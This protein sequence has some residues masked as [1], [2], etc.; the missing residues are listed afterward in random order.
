MAQEKVIFTQPTKGQHTYVSAEPKPGYSIEGNRETKKWTAKFNDEVLGEAD[1]RPAADEL[2]QEHAFPG[3]TKASS[4]EEKPLVVRLDGRQY[5]M[6]TA[7]RGFAP[8]KASLEDIAHATKFDI[9]QV[10][11]GV[12]AL[13]RKGYIKLEGTSSTITETGQ[14]AYD[15]YVPAIASGAPRRTTLDPATAEQRQKDREARIR[16]K[17]GFNEETDAYLLQP[18]DATELE[19]SRYVLALANVEHAKNVQRMY[20]MSKGADARLETAKAN[21]AKILENVEALRAGLPK[22]S[23]NTDKADSGEE[24]PPEPT[25]A[26]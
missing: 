2:V 15:E 10:M 11:T 23:A 1:S 20:P 12:S 9:T 25:A 6:L 18:I 7:I 26:E 22:P 3:S 16:A 13:G 4:G 21:A 5:A 19:E 17:E 14:K 8:N 24:A